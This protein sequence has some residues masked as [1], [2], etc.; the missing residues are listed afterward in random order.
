MNDTKI[1]I[2]FNLKVKR[3]SREQFAISGTIDMLG[4]IK[5]GYTVTL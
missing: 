2:D 4:D 1:L 5:N 3:I